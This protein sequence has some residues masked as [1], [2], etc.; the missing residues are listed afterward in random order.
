MVRVWQ[1]LDKMQSDLQD[2]EGIRAQESRV[3]EIEAD[4]LRARG[5]TLQA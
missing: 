5:R 4:F 3:K 2:R 1:I